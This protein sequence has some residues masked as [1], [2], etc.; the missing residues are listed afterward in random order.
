MS[1]GRK[2]IARSERTKNPARRAGFFVSGAPPRTGRVR[3]LGRHLAFPALA[4]TADA[5]YRFERIRD[6]STPVAGGLVEAGLVGVIADKVYGVHPALLAVISAAPMFGN[7][8]SVWW[9]RLAEGRARVPLLTAMQ[10]GLVALVALVALLPE[11]VLGGWL[12]ALDV[13]LARLLIG[14]I[15][16]VR[17]TV[18]TLNYPAEVRGR[19]TARLSLYTTLAITATAVLAGFSLDVDPQSFRM[20]ALGVGD[21]VGAV[22]RVMRRLC[23][24]HH[25][26][27]GLDV[28]ARRDQQMFDVLFFDPASSDLDFDFGDA[29]LEARTGASDPDTGDAG[30]GVLFGPLH[31]IADG[32]GCR[33]HIGDISALDTLAGTVPRSQDYHF[34]GFR[35]PHDHRRNSE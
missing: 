27:I 20:E 25:A 35:N 23:V 30:T 26:A 34:T 17:S 7:L 13:V 22:E 32:V 5:S 21:I 10:V 12:L 8:S 6:L 2:D 28:V 3:A 11:G 15:L 24:E 14:G 33:G 16:T 31:C 1:N 18:W 9:A 19:V 4:G 29:A